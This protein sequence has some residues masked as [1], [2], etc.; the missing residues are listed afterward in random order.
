MQGRCGS[1]LDPSRS[2]TLRPRS[3]C[4]GNTVS[5]KRVLNFSK[6]LKVVLR[7]LTTLTCCFRRTGEREPARWA[8]GRRCSRTSPTSTSWRGRCTATRGGTSAASSIF[9]C[10]RRNQWVGEIVT[11]SLW[12]FSREGGIVRGRGVGGRTMPS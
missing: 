9:C 8:A 12:E 6:T 1:P 7:S 5:W 4:S 2:C 11:P 10:K 3:C